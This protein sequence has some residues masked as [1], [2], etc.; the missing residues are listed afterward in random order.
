MGGLKVKSL[1]RISDRDYLKEWGR[2]LTIGIKPY[3]AVK[4]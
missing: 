1:Q 4:G 3:L 2:H